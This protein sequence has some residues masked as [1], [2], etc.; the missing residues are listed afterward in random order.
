MVEEEKFLDV[1]CGIETQ[2]K[3]IHTE[4]VR[5][6]ELVEKSQKQFWQR[7]ERRKKEREEREERRKKHEM[8]ILETSKHMFS[9]FLQPRNSDALLNHAIDELGKIG[10]R[11]G[12]CCP[13]C[14]QPGIVP[15]GPDTDMAYCDSCKQWSSIT[16]P[17]PQ[18]LPELPEP[19]KRG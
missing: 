17:D 4:L 5:R 9:K 7:E 12:M 3:D 11:P 8:E 13:R 14:G 15:A 6:N 10:F 1:L 18:N 19:N 16:E 2:L